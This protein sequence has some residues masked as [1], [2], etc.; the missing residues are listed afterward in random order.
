MCIRDRAKPGRKTDI[1]LVYL[2]GAAA[3]AKEA[4][5]KKWYKDSFVP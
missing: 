4:E 1:P 2:D 3:G 5:W